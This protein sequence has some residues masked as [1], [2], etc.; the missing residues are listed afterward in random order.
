[1]RNIISKVQLTEG[2]SSLISLNIQRRSY[3][4]IVKESFIDI[5]EGNLCEI[6]V[7]VLFRSSLA[8]ATIASKAKASLFVCC[9][10]F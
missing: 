8:V 2:E 4:G 3:M 1:M 10:T 5:R 7:D 9:L 6:V